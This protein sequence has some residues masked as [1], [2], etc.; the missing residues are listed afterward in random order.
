MNSV[1]IVLFLVFVMLSGCTTTTV[2]P[3][4]EAALVSGPPEAFSAQSMLIESVDFL[5]VDLPQSDALKDQAE[6][7]TLE[8]LKSWREDVLHSVS[9]MNNTLQLLFMNRYQNPFLL[10]YDKN[11]SSGWGR[12]ESEVFRLQVAREHLYMP[13]TFQ[14]DTEDKSEYVEAYSTVMVWLDE[15]EL[16]LRRLLE[17]IAI[18]GYRSSV[19]LEGLQDI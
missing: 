7:M 14:F 6:K 18:V 4:E 19:S 13:L 15:T 12:C 2:V 17:Y 5:A 1:K 11:A 3:M 8:E 10:D 9:L 16:R